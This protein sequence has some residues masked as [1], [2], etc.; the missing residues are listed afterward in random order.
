MSTRFDVHTLSVPCYLKK[1]LNKATTRVMSVTTP[2]TCSYL[3]L[4]HYLLEQAEQNVVVDCPLMSFVEHHHAVGRQ[5]RVQHHLP[6]E[7][8]VRAEL[9]FRLRTD[10]A[11]PR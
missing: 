7:H 1:Q 9:D 6:Q 8:P 4:P 11:H 5:Q 3:S 10:P 2:Y